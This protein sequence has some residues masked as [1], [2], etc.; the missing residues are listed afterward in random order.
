MKVT[1][2]HSEEFAHECFV[3]LVLSML[4]YIYHVKYVASVINSPYFVYIFMIIIIKC[5]T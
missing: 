5:G 1:A 3:G 2:L 4:L